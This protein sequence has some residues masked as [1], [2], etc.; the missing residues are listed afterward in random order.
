MNYRF[1]P[2]FAVLLMAC[3]QSQPLETNK[4]EVLGSVE[5]TFDL[6]NKTAKAAFTPA[7]VGSQALLSNQNAIAFSSNQFQAIVSGG[8]KFLVAKFNVSNNSG[9]AIDDLTLVAEHQLTNEGETALKN[10]QNFQNVNLTTYAES[11]KPAHA[12]SNATTVLGSEADTQFFTE[13]E[14]AALETQASSLLPNG[15][16]LFPYGY[17]ARATGSSISRNLGTG[18]TGTLTVGVQVPNTNEPG[19]QVNRFSMTFIAFSQPTA[20]RVSE[21]LEEQTSSGADTRATGFSASQIA[22]LAGT[23]LSTSK[24]ITNACRV[25]TVGSSASPNAFLTAA[26]S[27]SVTT[28][29]QCFGA[30]G[31]RNI[32]PAT[33]I[34]ETMNDM[35]IQTDGKIVLVGSSG[36][37]ANATRDWIIVR[38]NPDGSYDRS[39]GTNG[40][41]TIDFNANADV[42]F[43]VIQQTDGKL[44]VGGYGTMTSRDFA[45]VRLETNGTLDP[46]FATGGKYTRDVNGDSDQINAMTLQ[47]VSGTSYVVVAAQT[48]YFGTDA[49]DVAAF[50]LNLTGGTLDTGFNTGGAYSGLNIFVWNPTFSVANDP[51]DS[52]QGIAIDTNNKIIIGG[53]SSNFD[54]GVARLNTNGIL[55]SSFSSDGIFSTTQP[56]FSNYYNMLY[57]NGNVILVGCV[58]TNEINIIRYNMTTPAL[59]TTFGT[60]GK[61][62]YTPN[63]NPAC[64]NAAALDSNGRI[65]VAGYSATAS[66]NTGFDTLV[67]RL[68]ANGIAD[69]TFTA[70]GIVSVPLAATQQDQAIGIATDSSGKIVI[71]GLKTLSATDNDFFVLRMNP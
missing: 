37:A 67:A 31:I 30:A 22:V 42:A 17:V 3:Q 4:L 45:I 55:D 69:T 23:S 19:S 41:V 16:Y 65:L 13:T 60:S 18:A 38:L 10:V 12:M 34:Q 48:R 15:E 43:S 40:I 49:L 21:S 36:V 61:F 57:Q 32:S 29:D 33:N 62:S 71:A 47:T 1:L 11:I 46:N 52:P 58:G 39:F 66:G 7:R 59:D 53:G 51:N 9:A 56:Q 20:S 5:L 26:P 68:S 24:D 63:A 44:L 27:T 2:I 14:I 70:N 6:Q 35:I 25:R 28:L 54:V 8:N 50:R 64:A